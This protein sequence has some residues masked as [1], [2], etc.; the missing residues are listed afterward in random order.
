MLFVALSSLAIP[1]NRQR[2]TFTPQAIA[3]LAASIQD[4]G[5]FHP[6]VVRKE[7][8][9]YTLVA[10]ERRYRAMLSILECGGQIECNEELAPPDHIPV[11]LLKE[12][13]PLAL[14]EAELEE[15]TR[16][17]DLSWQELAT[18]TAEL[19]ALRSAQA[20]E[21]GRAQT[22]AAT[23]AE[24]LGGEAVDNLG[25]APSQVADAVILSRYLADPEVA[26]A[27]TQ[28]EA[29]KVVAKKAQRAKTAQLAEQYEIEKP[30]SPHTLLEG[31]TLDLTADL[32]SDHFQVILTDPPYGIDADKFG[33]QS[34]HGHN[35]S[36]S[37][38]YFNE[39]AQHI[40][41]EGFRIAAPKA[42]AY[43]FCDPRRFA[44]LQRC[45][46][47][48]GWYVWPIPLIWAKTTG[49]LP[50]PE[51]APR[52]M[53]EAILYAIKGNKPVLQV[54]GDVIFVPSVRGLTHGAQKPVDL[55]CD[56]LSRSASPGD[57]VIDFFAGSGTIF[58]AASR[59][60]CYATGIELD[61]DNANLCRVRMSEPEDA[62]DS[63]DN[64]SL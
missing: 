19:H 58:P 28:K 54:K 31:S 9:G 26:A 39:L 7:G 21:G 12:L 48:A 51:H 36:D 33:E 49:M 14:K 17:V 15:N 3:D 10:G 38:Q 23:A 60:K 8:E 56:L 20:A 1:D 57:R 61:T 64:L 62:G 63:L 27:K 25:A 32:P 5:L 47:E 16:R 42:H 41:K 50:R 44:F 22:F 52:R 40:A 6:I 45:F 29:M 55:Y 59:M 4:K 2:R 24:I 43:V 37:E 13:S 35:Y 46:E 30:A 53:Y 18:A 34:D 11:T